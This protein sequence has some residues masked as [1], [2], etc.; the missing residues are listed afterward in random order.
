M[1]TG[2]FRPIR[3][4][5]A[6]KNGDTRMIPATRA[7]NPGT[8]HFTPLPS[9]PAPDREKNKNPTTSA[10]TPGTKERWI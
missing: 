7:T 4:S 3:D 1:A 8:S 9:C 5:R 10:I 2:D 6:R